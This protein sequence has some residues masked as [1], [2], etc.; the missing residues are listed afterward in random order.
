MPRRA[1]SS[2]SAWAGKRCPPVP[3]AASRTEDVCSVTFVPVPAAAAAD[4]CSATSVSSGG[5]LS[6]AAFGRCRVSAS[7]M[8]SVIDTASIEEPPEEM[9]GSVMPLAGSRPTLTPML[10]S[11]CR[12]KSSA[13]PWMDSRVAA[14]F[15][16]AAASSAR[17]T[18]KANRPSS[19]RQAMTPYSSATTA[20]MKSV[21]ASGS[22]VLMVPSPGP[23]PRKPPSENE[24]MARSSCE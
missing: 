19:T 3:P 15:S 7:S 13:R 14:S 1:S 21:C 11:D 10:I 9:N 4:R 20:K 5:F 24:R 17:M 16:C 22:A 8:P 12:P 6:R 18:M 2:A 23:R